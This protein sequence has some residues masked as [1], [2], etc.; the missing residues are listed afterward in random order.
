[1]PAPDVAVDLHGVLPASVRALLA[2]RTGRLVAFACPEAGHDGPPLRDVEHGV[3]KWRRLVRHAGAD[4]REDDLLLAPP[5]HTRTRTSR[6]GSRSCIPVRR[7]AAS[8]GRLRDARRTWP[9]A[10]TSRGSPR[11]FAGPR[12]SSAASPTW[13]ARTSGPRWWLL[14]PA[15]PRIWGPPRKP[16]HAALWHGTDEREV[17]THAPDPALLAIAVDEVPDAARRVL[18]AEGRRRLPRSAGGSQR[19]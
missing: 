11:W 7:S 14:G 16:V 9:G 3:A 5:G 10:R 6:A 8:G 13:P 17:L 12:W 1:M 19:P 2:T 18:A 15:S 4:P